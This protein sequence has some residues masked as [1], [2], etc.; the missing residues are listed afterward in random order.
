MAETFTFRGHEGVGV[1]FRNALESQGYA[2]VEAVQEARYVLTY[3]TSQTQLED[4]YLDSD[5]LIQ[6]S[7]PRT[8]LLD[9]SPSTP[10]LAKEL[11]AIAAVNDVLA[12]EAP[13]VV[14]DPTLPLALSRENLTCFVADG[15]EGWDE[16]KP[17]LEVLCSEIHPTGPTG[18]AQLTKGFETLQV[19][20]AIGGTVEAYAF[21]NA[22]AK[23]LPTLAGAARQCKGIT[24]EAQKFLEAIRKRA[25]E[26]T[27]TVEMLMADMTA[28]LTC[29][30]DIDLI[31]PQAESI[32][33]LLELLA[34]IGGADKGATSL[35]LVYED[36]ESCAK[37]GLDWSRAE[38]AF[39]AV[40]GVDDYDDEDD[41]GD[42]DP[43]AQDYRDF[44]FDSFSAN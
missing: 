35:A 5:G 41:F 43:H 23:A 27:Y 30:D 8:C 21:S 39:G 15:D 9:F 29:A 20:A 28:A 33:N 19:C 12:V 18:S 36:E 38:T 4:V 14:K 11:N 16:A 6:V 44:G 34:V 40:E 24:S 31:L 25:F 10:N 3:C 7:A 17:I 1:V 13:L 2:Y 37:A 42:F 26:S 22:C 32:Q